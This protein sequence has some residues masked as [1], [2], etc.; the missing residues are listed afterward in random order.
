MSK[1]TAAWRARAI[2]AWKLTTAWPTA[3]SKWREERRRQSFGTK[4]SNGCVGILFFGIIFVLVPIMMF[5]VI[6]AGVVLYASVLSV[7]WG[8]C[9]LSDVVRRRPKL[10]VAA[11]AAHSNPSDDMPRTSGA[12]DHDRAATVSP[13]NFVCRQCVGTGKADG[14]SCVTCGGTGVVT[15]AW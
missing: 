3:Y 6:E 12:E 4:A 15:E 11:Q 1:P 9:V 13:R 10:G 14:G 7:V 2:A 5:L 8:A